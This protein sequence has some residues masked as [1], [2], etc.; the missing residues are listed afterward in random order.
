MKEGSRAGNGV[1]LSL[2]MTAVEKD[3]DCVPSLVYRCQTY[4]AE[5]HEDVDN[6]QEEEVSES[7]QQQIMGVGHEGEKESATRQ[8]MG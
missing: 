6:E 4:G 3:G 1:A 5:L 7:T 2:T 8:M